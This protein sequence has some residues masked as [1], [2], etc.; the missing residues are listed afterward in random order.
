[1]GV[2]KDYLSIGETAKRA[3]VATSALRFYETKGLIQ[4]TRGIGNQRAYHRSVLR[5]VSL[6]KVAQTLGL[7]LREIQSALAALPAQRTP[8]AR[9]WQKLSKQWRGDLDRRITELQALRDQLTSCIGCGC[10]SLKKCAL[11]NPQDK[12]ASLGAGPRFLM[13]DGD[14]D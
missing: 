3:G 14:D 12:A 9:D 1:M 7:S 6:I 11:Y 10:L 4:S 8:T 13:G 2:S 5:R